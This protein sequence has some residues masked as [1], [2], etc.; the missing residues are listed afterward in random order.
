MMA[1]FWAGIH[2]TAP[3]EGEGAKWAAGTA[4]VGVG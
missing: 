4:D 1:K 2:E 3:G